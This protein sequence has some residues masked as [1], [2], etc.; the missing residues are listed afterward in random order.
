MSSSSLIAFSR[1]GVS[2]MLCY[3]QNQH[4]AWR[5]AETQCTNRNMHLV[6]VDDAEQN[7]WIR[8]QALAVNFTGIIWIGG[9]DVAQEGNWIWIDGTQFWMG[10]VN[11]RAVNGLF[12]NW[13]TGQ[14]NSA[15]VEDC[16]AMWMNTDAWHDVACTNINAFLCQGP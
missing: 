14:P 8:A 11:G 15:G 13:D 3:A 6:R 4:R 10:L 2:Y 9:S 1:N 12:S 7:A 5:A 16:A